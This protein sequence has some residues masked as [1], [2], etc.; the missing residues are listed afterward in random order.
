[1]VCCVF[2]VL[3]L[4]MGGDLVVGWGGGCVSDVLLHGAFGASSLVPCND[5]Y[6]CVRTCSWRVSHS[7]CV[8]D[9]LL[10]FV[11]LVLVR[12][13]ESNWGSKTRQQ[14]TKPNTG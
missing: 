14:H 3:L 12:I 6:A 1:M 7:S 13:H 9:D 8:C 11:E 10:G 2:S 5:A 4:L